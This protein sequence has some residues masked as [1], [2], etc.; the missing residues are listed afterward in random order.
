MNTS[1]TPDNLATPN[2]F[3]HA[4]RS[5]CTSTVYIAGQVS[6]DETGRIV[7]T[8]DLAAQTAQIYANIG[9]ALVS[10]GA[11]FDDVV[12]TVLFV[13][14]LDP[15]KAGVIRD[16]RAAFF[17]GARLPASTMVGVASLA[18]PELLLEVEAIAMYDGDLKDLS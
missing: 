2:G 10:A 13:K 11:S 6:Y 5:T 18:K 12:K 1:Y 15:E 16:A 3:A 8:G 7:G 14:D 9:K 4:V 17:K